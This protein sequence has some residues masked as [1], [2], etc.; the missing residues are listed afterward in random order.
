MKKLN[1]DVGVIV[2]RFQVHELH[3]GH[4][5][6][7]DRVRSENDRVIVFVGLSP[8]RNTTRNPL[9]FRERRAMFQETYPDIEV[10]YI[11]DMHD[12]VLWS[13]ALDAQIQKW[14]K[15]HQSVTLYGSRDSFIPYYH[16]KYPTKELDSDIF[17]ASTE[18]RRR[19]AN[20]FPS[21]AP[22]RAGVIAASYNRFPTVYTTVDVA[23]IDWERRMLLLA[24]K[25]NEK[26]LRFIGGFAD[27][28]SNSFEEDASREVREEAG[29]IEIG[30]IQYVGS[31][32]VDDWRYRKEQDK[33]KTILF[34]ADYI[35]GRPVG[36]DDVESVH[37]VPLDEYLNNSV[38]QPEIVPE[39]KHLMTMLVNYLSTSPLQITRLNGGN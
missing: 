34:V 1:E 20:T 22:Y 31:R 11:D 35:F 39:H 37:W 18:I 9:D 12:D 19:I 32:L 36:G 17:V 29:G 26:A 27:I 15:P 2:G 6:L 30:N 23:V 13:N 25:R 3:E 7:I 16:G 24:K 28:N 21:T 33:I 14:S 4:R 10:Y 5:T 8:L 38:N